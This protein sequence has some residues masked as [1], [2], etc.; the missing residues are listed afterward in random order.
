MEGGHPN[1]EVETMLRF[2]TSLAALVLLAGSLAAQYPADATGFFWEGQTTSQ[3]GVFC[4]GFSCTPEPITVAAGE[5]GTLSIRKELNDFYAIGITPTGTSCIPLPGIAHAL[6][7]DPPITILWTGALTVPS[8]V[9]ACPSGLDPR[10]V[11]VPPGLAPGTSFVLQGLVATI[12]FAGPE[13]A[14]TTALRFTVL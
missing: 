8:G 9:L 6:V 10:T 13:F 12:G 4:W 14:F 11:V 2:S 7:L 5:T 3:G 1:S